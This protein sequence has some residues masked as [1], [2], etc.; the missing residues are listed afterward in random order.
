MVVNQLLLDAGFSLPQGAVHDPAYAG[1]SV[2]ALYSELARLQD[3]APNK[4][5]KRPEAQ[6]ETEQTEGGAGSRAKG[7]AKGKDRM[8]PPKANAARPN[9]WVDTE[10]LKAA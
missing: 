4:G 3:E 2:E 10:L 5:A 6:E 8:I 1:F 7:K 9:C